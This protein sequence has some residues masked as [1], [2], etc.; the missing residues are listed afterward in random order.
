M[1]RVSEGLYQ[2]G[3]PLA[4]PGWDAAECP[5]QDVQLSPFHLEPLDAFATSGEIWATVQSTGGLICGTA[6]MVVSG[7]LYTSNET[8][9]EI[10]S[11]VARA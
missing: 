8:A 7:D 1:L 9:V 6:T 2:R 3:E 10:L 4:V 5:A 11:R